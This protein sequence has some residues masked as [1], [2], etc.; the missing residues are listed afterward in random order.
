MEFG[1]R[2]LGNRSI[3]ADARSEGMQV[4][5]N[6]RSLYKRIYIREYGFETLPELIN[7]LNVLWKNDEVMEQIKTVVGISAFKNEPS[8]A[9]LE[10]AKAD[11]RESVEGKLSVFR[12]NF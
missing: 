11:S 1:P 7:E 5:L 6:H 2:A 12:Y 9:I 8:E 10:E 4:K 3:I